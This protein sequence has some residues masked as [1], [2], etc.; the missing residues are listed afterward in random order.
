MNIDFQRKTDEILTCWWET[1]PISATSNGIHD[2]D[3]RLERLDPDSRRATIKNYERFVSELSRFESSDELLDDDEK[4]DLR[5]L[6]SHL[7]TTIQMENNYRRVE[8]DATV[9][10][11]ICLWSIY[12]LLMRDFAPLETRMESVLARLRQVPRVL[13]E[14]KVNLRS[15]SDLPA[16]WTRMGMEVAQSGMG[17]FA[18]LVPMYASRVPALANDVSAANNAAI[19]ALDGYTSFL[20]NEIM[21]ASDGEYRLG[22]K[23]FD[24]LLENGYMLPYRSDD[25]VE[26]GKRCIEE[27][28]LALEKAAAQIDPDR[29][30]AELVADFKQE[31]PVAEELIGF[32]RKEIERARRF[33]VE[34]DIVTIPD[35]ESLAVMETPQFKTGRIPYA[36]YVMPAPFEE[37]QE[38]IFWVTQ[39]DP[40]LPVEQQREQ[41]SG[42]SK[43][44]IVLK[45]VH[46]AFPGHHLQL[47]HSNRVDSK[48]RRAFRT[49]LFAEGWALYC[50]E[51][52]FEQGF[53]DLRSRLFQLKDELWRACRVVID[54]ELHRGRMGFQEAVKM[55]T[56]V[57]GL[58]E[59]N[60]ISEVKRYTQSPT[61]PMSY[62]MGKLAIMKILDDYRNKSKDNFNLKSFHD[63]LLSYGTIPVGLVSED[64]L[65]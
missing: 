26:I 47:L 36:A 60:A 21:P 56:D 5:I 50:E 7:D 20:Q 3:D 59:V 19:M 62:I 43:A 45:S 48:I 40:N 16:A 2:Y 1:N 27:T 49:S 25:L 28:T 29:S 64:M 4:L 35:G 33:V 10:P 52:M 17:F 12:M 9:Y 14:G 46:E 54:V 6:K 41:L 63:Q 55:L 44:A 22:E 32:Y 18:G 37:L 51:M 13:E 15:S 24:Y 53:Y 39:V 57:A 42:H 11:D 8:R 31:T 34:K 23:M 38:G 65:K 61:Q 30:W 58:E